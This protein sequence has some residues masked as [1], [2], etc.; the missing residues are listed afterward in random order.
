M[1]DPYVK[2]F[3]DT[4]FNK[5]FSDLGNAAPLPRIG[6]HRWRSRGPCESTSPWPVDWLCESF[7]CPIICREFQLR[8]E[9]NTVWSKIYHILTMETF[10]FPDIHSEHDGF[11]GVPLCQDLPPPR[12]RDDGREGRRAHLLAGKLEWGR[13][14][15][16]YMRVYEL[17]SA[18]H[19]SSH[20]ASCSSNLCKNSKGAS[21]KYDDVRTEGLGDWPKSRK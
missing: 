16:R 1:A 4:N 15:F 18:Q 13:M 2:A 11:L 12:Q 9:N 17:G 6:C 21:I 14:L 19:F 3:L 10:K 8:F 7:P 20:G 5:F